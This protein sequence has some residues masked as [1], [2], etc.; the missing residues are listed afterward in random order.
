MNERQ[1]DSSTART[2]PVGAWSMPGLRVF[3]VTLAL[4]LPGSF[5][6]LPLLWL[7]R[8]RNAWWTPSYAGALG[9]LATRST[10]SG[11]CSPENSTASAE[12][13]TFGA[14]ISI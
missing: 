1:P 8:R 7:W 13:P 9:P 11:I 14:H 6:I 3:A 2:R 5:V 10:H 4:L 12:R